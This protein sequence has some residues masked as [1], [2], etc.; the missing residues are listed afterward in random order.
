MFD[1]FLK[2]RELFDKEYHKRSNV[3]SAFYMIKRKFGN[4]LKTKRDDSQVNEILMKCLCHNLAV[5][6]Q[7]S[8]EL[9]LEIDLNFCAK[10]ILAQNPL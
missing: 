5:L 8:F 9:G 1:R 6:V 3:E 4:S 10:T 7:E 2:K